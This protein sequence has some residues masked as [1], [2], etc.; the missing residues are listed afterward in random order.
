[1]LLIVVG[2]L[3]CLYG[4][5]V[6]LINAFRASVLWGLGSLFIGPVM[7]VFV[8]LNWSENMKPFLINVAG[9]VL[10][11]AGAFMAAPAVAPQWPPPQ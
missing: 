2:A 11:V 5:I 7:L 6:V 4:T 9:A 10:L 3:M 8:I 1:M